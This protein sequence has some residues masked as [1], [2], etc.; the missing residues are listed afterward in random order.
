M[1]GCYLLLM[2]S[3]GRKSQCLTGSRQATLVRN[4]TWAAVMCGC[5]ATL[6]TGKM[7][8]FADCAGKGLATTFYH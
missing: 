3:K 1:A 2:A 5:E 4:F 6:N 8:G 7:P